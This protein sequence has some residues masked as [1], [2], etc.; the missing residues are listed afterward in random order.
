[1]VP[2]PLWG[3]TGRGWQQ[4]ARL[5]LVTTISGCGDEI[6]REHFF[7]FDRTI[8]APR[9]WLP[10]SLS[11]PPQGGRNVVAMPCPPPATRALQRCVH[12][13]GES[14]NERSCNALQTLTP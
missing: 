7:D 2:S 1:M 12:L 13:L 3:G 14:G 5:R 8:E 6:C 9:F 10:L 11:F 4:T